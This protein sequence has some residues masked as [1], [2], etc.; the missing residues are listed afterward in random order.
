MIAYY[1]INTANDGS[2]AFA[3]KFDDK[4]EAGKYLYT[5]QYNFRERE[6]LAEDEF[7]DKYSK[8]ADAYQNEEEAAGDGYA[9]DDYHDRWTNINV[10]DPGLIFFKGLPKN[11]QFTPLS[12][13]ISL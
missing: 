11:L 3:V 7:W 8:P 1:V 6:L 13:I 12:G 10:V 2:D 9:W 4:A 5:E